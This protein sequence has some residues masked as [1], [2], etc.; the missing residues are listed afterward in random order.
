MN[1]GWTFS[2]RFALRV[3]MSVAVNVGVN[4]CDEVATFGIG[5]PCQE[6]ESAN[7]VRFDP[8]FVETTLFFRGP[9]VRIFKPLSQSPSACRIRR[10]P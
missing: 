3:S 8:N 7:V 4:L 9:L 6:E 2:A 1:G 10:S 5:S